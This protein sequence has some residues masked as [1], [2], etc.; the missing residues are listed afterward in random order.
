VQ[1]SPRLRTRKQGDDEGLRDTHLTDIPMPSHSNN[2]LLVILTISVLILAS[3]AQAFNLTKQVSAAYSIEL[4]EFR[5]NAFPLTVLVT[6]NQWG[7]IEYAENLH[8][9]LDDWIAS[10]WNYTQSYNDTS[11]TVIDYT[12]YL[13]GVNSTSDPDVVVSFNKSEMPPHS[14]IV[15]LTVYSY[16]D[17]SHMPQRP[18]TVNL[19]TYSATASDLFV[20]DVFMHEFGHVLGLGH[21]SSSITSNGPELMYE[22][23][24]NDQQVYP[25]TLD[26]Y[27]LSVLYASSKY[28]QVIQLPADIQYQML[29]GGNVPSVITRLWDTYKKYLPLIALVLIIVIVALLIV[30]TSRRRPYQEKQ[31]QPAPPRPPPPPE[32]I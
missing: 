20:K 3:T 24:S 25:S 9:A 27:A 23:S 32:Q 1:T 21:A 2:R 29:I 12:F 22:S 7:T 5:W 19:T 15:G 31:Q 26:V 8:Q 18:I 4:E 6:M 16:D 11:L 13:Q 17:V 30:M 14:G 10:I 28:S